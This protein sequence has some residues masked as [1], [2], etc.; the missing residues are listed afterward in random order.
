MRDLL[1]F[2]NYCIRVFSL[3][4]G[5]LLCTSCGKE[6]P[7][8]PF[9]YDCE[10]IAFFPP[11]GIEAHSFSGL[12]YQGLYR[13]TADRQVLFRPVL[14]TTY[15]DG[16]KRIQQSTF[17]NMQ[18]VKRLIVIT[19]PTYV[20]GL[21][22]RG[23]AD[24]IIDTDSTKVVVLGSNVDHPKLYSAHIPPYGVMYKAGYIASKMDDVERARVYVVNQS[25]DYYI[26]AVE[27]FKQGYE[28]DGKKL[29]GV[30][31][32]E[33]R[34]IDDRVGFSLR[35]ELYAIHA[36]EYADM[37]DLVMPM[38]RETAMGF[39]RYNRENPGAFYTLGM[40]ID[41]SDYA[42]DVPYSC[43]SRWDSVAE[44]VVAD[45]DANRLERS[46][47]YGLE[48]GYTAIVA[49][50]RFKQTIQPLSDEIHN[51]AIQRENEYVR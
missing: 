3:C 13:A 17:Y 46:Q 7:V 28:R 50:S 38:C 49:A 36:K 35:Q 48:D 27:G 42:N 18:G 44:Q 19:D 41:M 26:E 22:E 6:E 23:I 34:V 5:L 39:Y 32:L 45:W 51:E 11:E 20:K 12:V 9:N 1:K 24:N 43:I 21:V 37:C 25:H 30:D 33:D 40:D 4:L 31:N 8:E 2:M 14:P 29:D 15:D 10:V 47:C 16:L